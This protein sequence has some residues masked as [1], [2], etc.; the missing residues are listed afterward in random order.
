MGGLCEE[1]DKINGDDQDLA[2]EE[3]WRR[4]MARKAEFAGIL[5]TP[6]CNT[7]TRARRRRREG[8]GGPPPLRGPR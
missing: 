8:D 4:L 5:M 7:F 1:W 2:G 6:P 3:N